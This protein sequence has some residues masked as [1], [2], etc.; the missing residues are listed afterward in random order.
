MKYL[1]AWINFKGDG[2]TAIE[3]LKARLRKLMWI[4]RIANRPL[5]EQILLLNSKIYP[6][7]RYSI[8]GCQ[9]W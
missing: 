1:G 9:F 3:K 7:I 4:G 5:D 2:Y 6:H 8:Y